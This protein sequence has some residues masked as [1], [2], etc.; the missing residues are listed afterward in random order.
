[1][2]VGVSGLSSICTLMKEGLCVQ[3]V[4]MELLGFG[5]SNYRVILLSGQLGRG[6]GEGSGQPKNATEWPRGGG[7][8]R[9]V[10]NFKVSWECF[11]R[12]SADES[13][14]SCFNM[15]NQ[16]NLSDYMLLYEFGFGDTPLI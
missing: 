8:G 4:Q 14:V 5:I 11:L 15:F 2:F 13:C 3:K 7:P 1:M 12:N 10:I 9:R 16:Y 6:G